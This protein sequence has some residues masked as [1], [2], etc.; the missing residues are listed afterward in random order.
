LIF[1]NNSGY[2]NAPE[3]S[4]YTYVACLVDPLSAR[5]ITPDAFC[6]RSEPSCPVDL[7]A[8]GVNGNADPN[9]SILAMLFTLPN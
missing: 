6:Y 1:H 2:A 8:S 5:S 7:F 9:T 3:Y 4:V